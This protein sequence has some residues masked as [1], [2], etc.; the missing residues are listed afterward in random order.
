VIHQHSGSRL[1]EVMVDSARLQQVALANFECCRS[2]LK[3]LMFDVVVRFQ[4]RMHAFQ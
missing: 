1:D 2:R 4:G 3:T